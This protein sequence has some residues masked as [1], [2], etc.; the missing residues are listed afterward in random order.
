MEPE[1]MNGQE[2]V[3]Y[4]ARVLRV[5]AQASEVLEDP[6]IAMQWMLRPSVL[7]NGDRPLDALAAQA[8]YDRVQSLLVRL[9]HGVGI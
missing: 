1:K 7:L 3:D 6:A 5:H 9:E 2:L 4:A 8:G